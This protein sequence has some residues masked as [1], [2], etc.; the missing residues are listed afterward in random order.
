MKNDLNDKLKIQTQPLSELETDRL[1]QGIYR[2]I[3]VTEQET[4]LPRPKFFSR[5]V[6]IPLTVT[7]LLIIAFFGTATI[8]AQAKPGDLMFPVELAYENLQ[9][10]LTF[11]PEKKAKLSLQFSQERMKEVK[12]VLNKDTKPVPQPT[13]ELKNDVLP[14]ASILAT[15]T[16]ATST[17]TTIIKSQSKPTQSLERTH[18]TLIGAL[19]YLENAKIELE[20]SGNRDTAEAVRAMVDQLSNQTQDY[21]DD[22]EKIKQDIPDDDDEKNQEVRNRIDRSE[23]RLREKFRLDREREDETKD[24]SDEQRAEELNQN[25]NGEQREEDQ[26]DQPEDSENQEDGD[27]TE[28]Q[29]L[30]DQSLDFSPR[31]ELNN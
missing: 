2:T 18:Q 7:S 24:E 27:R 4:M 31:E 29:D 13:V 14:A 9:L 8:A 19:D 3:K 5:L 12:E 1:W 21:I 22:L 20:K 26:I 16:E 25:N 15:T 17:Q 30:S 10:N 11:N 23:K 6:Y 28:S